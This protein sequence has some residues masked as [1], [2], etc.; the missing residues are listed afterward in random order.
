MV[1]IGKTLLTAFSGLRHCSKPGVM[2]YYFM[3]SNDIQIYVCGSELHCISFCYQASKFQQKTHFIV[4]M[5]CNANYQTI[6]WPKAASND[7]A[8]FDSGQV[9]CYKAIS[10]LSNHFFNFV[11][12]LQQAGSDIQNPTLWNNS[13]FGCYRLFAHCYMLFMTFAFFRAL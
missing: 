8:N 6:T 3:I 1:W 12:E 7:S 4:D 9:M 10:L 5:P 11:L 2:L 13:K